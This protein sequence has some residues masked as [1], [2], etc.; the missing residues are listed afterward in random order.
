MP[1]TFPSA[2]NTELA[3][4]IVNI[5]TCLLVTLR[6]GTKYGF[7]NHVDPVTVDAVTYEPADSFLPTVADIKT[8]TAVDNFEVIA[9][10]T[11]NR[12]NASDILAG[13]Y[14]GATISEFVVKPSDIAGTTS[15]PILRGFIGRIT[16]KDGNYR[17]EF[18]SLSQVLSQTF[19]D[20]IQSSCRYEFGDSRCT[21]DVSTVTFSRTVGAVGVSA[22]AIPSVAVLQ[23]NAG[24][25]AV[26]PY[27]ADANYFN[28]DSV[29]TTA[30]SIDRTGVS[31]P[32]PEAVYQT[33]RGAANGQPWYYALPG[34]N[35][36]QAYLLRLHW[37]EIFYTG[38]DGVGFRV[39][40]VKVNGQLMLSHLDVFQQAGGPNIAIVEE[41]FVLADGS[42]II[43]VTF[44]PDNLN[45][46]SMVNGLE[47]Y[48]L[49]VPE[50][51]GTGIQ[52]GSDAHPTGYY[53]DGL[54][55][56]TS[57]LNEGITLKIKQHQLVAGTAVVVPQLSFP[58]EVAPGDTFD[59]V[60]G[61]DKQWPT[62][63]YKW[64]NWVNYGGEPNLPTNDL[65]ALQGR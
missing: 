23:Q 33:Y 49:D 45:G 10:L 19:G 3:K 36:G 31:N 2:L 14:N 43:N 17:A 26:S 61:C 55:T 1:R 30:S 54:M 65:L 62:C 57:G 20:A 8:G 12:V 50:I 7:T 5:V 15:P 4:P 37:A 42:G 29:W 25:G 46:G 59:L 32:A 6:D 16:V 11:G 44:D 48:T 40:D 24:G 64:A 60:A 51:D 27:A 41:L 56:C 53:V 47:V 13:K 63:K 39:F 58:Y 22:A 52:F 18:R 9:I 34:F 35:A 28:T 21:F 38:A